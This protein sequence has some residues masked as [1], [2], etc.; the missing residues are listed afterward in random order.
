[1]QADPAFMDAY[2]STLKFES[3]E[4]RRKLTGTDSLSWK[5]KSWVLGIKSGDQ[6]RAYDW[7]RLKK[8]RVINDQLNA[9]QLAIILAPDDKSFFAFELPEPGGNLSLKSDTVV[10]NHKHFRLDGRGL[11]TSFSLKPVQASQE[12]WHSWR[13]F[14]PGTSKY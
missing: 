9:K 13:T 11:D 14:N 12:F 7:N 4:S 6:S 3:G 8:E 5:D 1:M 10:F 2:D